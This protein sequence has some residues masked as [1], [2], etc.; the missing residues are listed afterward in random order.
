MHMS[1]RRLTRSV[2]LVVTLATALGA[3]QPLPSSISVHGY[4]TQ[5]YGVSRNGLVTGLGKEGTADY[6]RAAILARFDASPDNRFVVQLAHRRLGDSPTMQF[7][8]N[9]KLDMAFFEQRFRQGT[10]VRIGKTVMP[11]GIYNEIRYAGTLQPF[12]RAPLSVYWEGTYTSE[13]IDGLL[14]SHRFRAGDAWELSTDVYGGSYNFLE[15][16]TV[17][18]SPTTA[19]VYMGARLQAKNVVGGQMWLAT[20]IDGLR[21]G[22]SARRHKDV[23]GV[24]PRGDGFNSKEVTASVDGSFEKWM[25]RA[26]GNR[27]QTQGAAVVSRYVQLGFRPIPALSVNAQAE[28]MNIELTGLDMATTGHRDFTAKMLR[29]N[30]VSV[31]VYLTS[32]T[33]LKLEAHRTNGH[34]VE[35]PTNLFGPPRRGSYFISSFSVSF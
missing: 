2:A 13:T 11:W 10:S 32:F 12:Y 25:V 16:G 3:Q 9:V 22:A 19:P 35:E 6:R 34:N 21:V 4:L 30:A 17:Q 33:V 23:G 15:F 18:T 5:A 8:E 28:H 29:D 27:T 24:Y 14:A 20:P 26:E 1:I 7:E 31:N